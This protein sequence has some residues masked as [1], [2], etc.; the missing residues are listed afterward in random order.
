MK[1]VDQTIVDKEIG[2]CTRACVASILE[3]PIDDVPNFITFGATWFKVFWPY[4]QTFGY[5]YY[6]TGWIKGE[7]RPHG[8]VLKDSHSIDGYVI[9]SVPSR[10]FDEVGHSVV[11]NLEGVVVHDPN[12]NKAWQDINVVESGDLQHWMMIGK[13]GEREK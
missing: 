2:D 7:D 4:L 11:M 10:T 8:I 9:A 6:G 12:P 5:D 3:L 1:P 13:K